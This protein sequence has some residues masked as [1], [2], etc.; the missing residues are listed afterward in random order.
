M[1]KRLG[2]DR[3][4]EHCGTVFYVSLA[5]QRQPGGG[6]F[7]S[8]Q[9]VGR[10]SRTIHGHN[11]LIRNPT[12]QSWAGM[13]QRCLNPKNRMY[14]YYGARGIGVCERWLV[15]ANFLADMDERLEGMTLERRDNSKGYSPENCYWATRKEQMR[16][17]RWNR[18]L[19][20]DGRT[21]C[22][23]AW[24]EETGLSRSQLVLR[25]EKGRRPL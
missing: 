2:E 17:T 9:C 20:F 3:P 1:P 5:R 16:N 14:S 21:Q 15:Y 4:C 18:M 10:T 25:A 23:S 22:V 11:G 13:I 19:T 8:R 7:C 24:V 6:R 12:Y